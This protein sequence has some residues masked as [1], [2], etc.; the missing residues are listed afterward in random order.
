MK[1][2]P[3][4]AD[5]GPDLLICNNLKFRKRCLVS[6]LPNTNISSPSATSHG[7]QTHSR[8]Q[9]TKAEPSAYNKSLKLSPQ[10]DLITALRTGY[11]LYYAKKSCAL[12]Q[13]CPS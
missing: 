3:F 2:G 9:I 10:Q 11:L 4:V 13:T 5:Q 8:Q 1:S 7:S 6:L 12:T